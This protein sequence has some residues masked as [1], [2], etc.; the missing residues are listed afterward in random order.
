MMFI[1]KRG[2]RHINIR[3]DFVFSHPNKTVVNE[4]AMR[5]I[6]LIM[7]ICSSMSCLAATPSLTEVR[8]L[9]QK[10]AVTEN[11][12]KYLI[13]LLAPYNEKNSPLLS[14]YKAGATMMMARYVF[15]PF[16]K[17][18]YFNK[19]KKMM[20]KAIE[21][22]K[23]NVELRFLRF[24]VQTNI[25][26]FLGYKNDIQTDKLFLLQSISQLSDASLKRFMVAYL[27]ESG[28]LTYIEKQ[29]LK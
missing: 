27:N 23:E 29:K 11:S 26:F 6:A 8:L 22:D 20:E 24:G 14:G 16:N 13:G 9:Y 15:S 25:P 10:A 18:S 17:L 2:N 4:M 19:G 12:C 28:E 5:R 7:L 21:A 1:V 3:I